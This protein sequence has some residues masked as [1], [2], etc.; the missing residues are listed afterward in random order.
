[1]YT[2]QRIERKDDRR[3]NRAYCKL[4]KCNTLIWTRKLD[5]V[6]VD[7]DDKN[8]TL[9]DRDLTGKFVFS[10]SQIQIYS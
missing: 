6:R 9:F 10:I 8:D 2:A 7:I 5:F 4:P 1:M 3:Q